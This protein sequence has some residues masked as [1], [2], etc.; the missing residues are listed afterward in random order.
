M[1]ASDQPIV[2]LREPRP[3][4]VDGFTALHARVWQETY[5]GLMADALVDDLCAEDFRPVWESITDV[6]ARDAVPTDGR[7]FLVAVAGDTPVAFCMHGPARDDDAP[8]AHQLGSLNVAP[9]HQG[10][11][12]ARRLLGRALGGGE[13]CLWVAQG[14]GH[15]IR[16]YER[17][18]FVLDGVVN[19]DRAD[20]M[21]EVR[22]V[23]QAR[24]DD[25]ARGR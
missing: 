22:M 14:N 8:T 3:G 19:H 11:G 10:S 13:A 12:V 23:R 25:D 18:G 21:V 1:S 16:F 9:E 24:G 5:R 6:Y 20:G 15:A 7:G 4:D 17:E 2:E